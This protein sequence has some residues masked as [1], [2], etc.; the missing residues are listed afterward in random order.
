ML[1]WGMNPGKQDEGS[2]PAE[3]AFSKNPGETFFKSTTS[4]RVLPRVG[5]YR[6]LAAHS[7]VIRCSFSG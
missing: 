1:S 3:Q 6:A 5:F 7:P 2:L 4:I